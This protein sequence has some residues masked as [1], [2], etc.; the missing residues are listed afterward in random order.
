MLNDL[1]VELTAM[2][3]DRAFSATV[4]CGY[5]TTVDRMIDE[6]LDAGGNYRIIRRL[7]NMAYDK[8]AMLMDE[9]YL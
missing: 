3:I 8:A 2:H 6:Y 9:G 5:G 1:L 4:Y 7:D